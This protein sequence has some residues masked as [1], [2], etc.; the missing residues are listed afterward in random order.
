MSF[1]TPIPPAKLLDILTYCRVGRGETELAFIRKYIKP[2]GGTQDDYGNFW[3]TVGANPNIMWSVHLDTVHHTEGRQAVKVEN[4][5]V[6]LAAP[7]VG[8]C[9]GADD[10]AGIW[11][12]LEMI[13]AKV[14][15]LYIFHREEETGG[16]GSTYIANKL[17][18]LLKDIQFAVALDRKGYDSV[19]THQGGRCCSDMFANQLAGL[20][21]GAF[22]PDP[23]GLF[24][25]T[26]NYTTLISECTNISVGY[27]DQHGPK[28]RQDLMFLIALRDKLCSIN[29]SVLEAHRD[30]AEDMDDY[31]Y[32]SA[33]AEWP[34][35]QG[36]GGANDLMR[37]VRD[38]PAFI[39][40]L[41]EDHGYTFKDL[42]AMLFE[43]YGAG[44]DPAHA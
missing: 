4:G 23:T 44:F 42:D 39:A 34:S 17:P 18:Y 25:D 35:Y 19:I 33:Y 38:N 43:S 6:S 16:R 8:S 30:P 22:E 13:G 3:V 27:F 24:T 7:K 37:L 31:D 9:L 11:L 10:G 29:F 5:F 1:V 20:L 26:A 40:E 21:G 32:G 41:L 15:G 14:P 36:R 12:A 28:E 2:L